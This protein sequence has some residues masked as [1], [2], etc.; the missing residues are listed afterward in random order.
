MPLSIICMLSSTTVSAAAPFA[1]ST[2]FSDD[3]VLQRSPAAASV[4]GLVGAGVHVQLTL[5]YETE[6]YADHQIV[7]TAAAVG[8]SVLAGGT[9]APLCSAHCLAA[10]HC[11]QGQKGQC[12]RPSCNMGCI[13]A[14]RTN[15][16]AQCK[17]SCAE[18]A[19]GCEYTVVSPAG[20]W[21]NVGDTTQNETFEMCKSSSSLTNGTG[22]SSCSGVDEQNRTECEQGCDFG[23]PSATVAWKAILAP[24]T[25]SASARYTI[26][27]TTSDGQ[28][29]TLRRV[30]FGDVFLCSGQSNMDL[31]LQYTFSKPSIDALVG[32][33]KYDAISLFMLGSM[34]V[35]YIETEALWAT[36]QGSVHD[37]SAG[38][39]TWSNTTSD[40]NMTA[41]WSIHNQFSA[42]C[43]YFA[44]GLIDQGHTLPIG[45][46]QSAIGGSQIEAWMDDEA[47]GVCS[48]QQLNA[49]GQ[50]P[51]S[52]LFK[53]MIAPFVNM[54]IGGAPPPPPPP[55]PLSL[56]LA[57]LSSFTRLTRLRS[58][59]LSRLRVAVV[60]G[61]EQ[62]RWDDGK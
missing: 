49:N 16:A 28:T 53:G 31:A 27:A 5:T 26:T 7:S 50:A 59:S 60:S 13:L 21:H 33:G 17:S 46:I 2:G 51:P 29:L 24:T 45:L 62:L 15:T 35:K 25:G 8:G 23:Q 44:V 56:S 30:R 36:S 6:F 55:P 47:L 52:R 12:Q 54:S 48:E 4:Y 22:C 20:R 43:F 34:G 58:L 11:A 61:R 38:G 1:F 18:A 57:E 19:N 32:Q 3:M 37:P 10:G 42:T 9:N 39:G 14:G 40:S 41:D